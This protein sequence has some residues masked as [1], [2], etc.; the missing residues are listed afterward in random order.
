MIEQSKSAAAE[1]SLKAAVVE[2]QRLQRAVFPKLRLGLL[3][4]RMRSDEKEEVMTRFRGREIDILVSTTVI[5][6]G[7]DVPNATVM[8]VE[9]A[10][11]FGLSQLHQLRGR[12]GRGAEK[13]ICILVAP[14]NAGEEAVARLETMVATSDGFAIAEADLKLRGPGEFFGTKQHGALSLH[15]ADP[16]RDRE[17]LDLARRGSVSLWSKTLPRRAARRRLLASLEPGMAAPLSTRFRGLMG[18]R[19]RVIAGTYRS[20]KLHTLRG[21][22]LQAHQRPPARNAFQYHR[23]DD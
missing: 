1:R 11:R 7:V 19:M 21:T 16:T 18:Q 4:G 13:S 17:F 2:Y 9:H 23:P 20:R 5:E 12:I 6:V 10:E 3:H 14:K 15:M 22:A 8:V